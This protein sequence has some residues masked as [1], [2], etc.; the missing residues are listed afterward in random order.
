VFAASGALLWTSTELYGAS[1]NF[2]GTLTSQSDLEKK[3]V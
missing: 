2:F 3:T 1:A